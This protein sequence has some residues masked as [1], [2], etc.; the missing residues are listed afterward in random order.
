MIFTGGLKLS[1][2]ETRGPDMPLSPVLPR[3]RPRGGLI[4]GAHQEIALPSWPT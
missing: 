1:Y 3:Q 4:V 2:L